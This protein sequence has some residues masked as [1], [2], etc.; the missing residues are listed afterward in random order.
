M[1]Q[2]ITFSIIIITT[3][4]SCG[5]SSSPVQNEAKITLPEVN[6]Q[7]ETFDPYL[8]LTNKDTSNISF[9]FSNDDFFYEQY[10]YGN[11]YTTAIYPHDSYFQIVKNYY[12]DGKI[13]EKGVAF[14]TGHPVGMW[15][16]FDESGI[17]VDC[18]NTDA[19]YSF[20]YEDVINYCHS[21]E[22]ALTRGY[23]SPEWLPNQD[24]Q[25]RYR[26]G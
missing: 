3:L 4:V 24:S 19:G 5:Q 23:V 25:T 17:L 9:R 18:K 16:L 20:T 14:H 26:L 2:F 12:T 21:N 1:R 13:K 6:D 10:G 15:Y 7:F 22:I 11:G 8:Y